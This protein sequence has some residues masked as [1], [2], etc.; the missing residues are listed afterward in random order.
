MEESPV[1]DRIVVLD[2]YTLNP[3]DLSWDGVEEFGE[4]TVHDRTAD[5]LI[6]E[7]A[8]G[9]RFAL[10]NK[11]PFTSATLDALPDLA[12]IGVLATGYNTVD[13]E[14]AS[15]RDMVVTNVPT[16]GTDSVAQHA[17]A[18]MLELVRQ[19]ALH[20]NA[21]HAGAW[22]NNVDW[23][24]ALTP[25]TELSGKVL[26]VV[27]IGRIG[28]ALAR[29]GAAMGMTI[30]A[31]DEY[32]PDAATLAGLE[33]EF[34]DV[35]DLFRRADVIS[36]HCPLTPETEHLVNAERLALMRPQAL[37]LNTSRGPLVDNQALADALHEG[38]I[39][40][41]G[42][43]VLDVEP[44]PADNPLLG[45]PNCVITPHIAWYAQASRQRLMDIAVENLRAFI[46]G[47]PVNTV[48]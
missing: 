8:A 36:L 40:G 1:A 45:A 22:T 25:M 29:I 28:R 31:Q 47:A 3:G 2:G 18:L 5:D 42:L 23:C 11:V 26:G 27:G 24:F 37:L 13:V 6:L 10:T 35:D 19:P 4:L 44:P 12:Y 16:Y 15:A 39:G 32:P 7:R 9:C 20:S 43:D 21:V 48:S 34:T 46:A 33:V 17:T 30:I 14:A 41:A 38:R